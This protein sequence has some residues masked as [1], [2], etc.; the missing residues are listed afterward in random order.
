MERKCPF[1]A[2][3]IQNGCLQQRQHVMPDPYYSVYKPLLGCKKLQHI[4]RT[5]T[6]MIDDQLTFLCHHKRMEEFSIIARAGQHGILLRLKLS[7]SMTQSLQ[8]LLATSHPGR[9]ISA[10]LMPPSSTCLWC[11]PL[12]STS[13]VSMRME[14]SVKLSPS[15][16]LVS[17]HCPS[18]VQA[19]HICWFMAVFSSMIRL[20]LWS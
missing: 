14:A 5:Q 16:N 20:Q 18:C 7:T 9:Y 19:V 4:H 11:M 10:L 15:S 2:P 8:L 13:L 6:I 17:Q 12:G 1:H 3:P